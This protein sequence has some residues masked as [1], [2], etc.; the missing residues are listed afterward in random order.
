MRNVSV[1]QCI[2]NALT[3]NNGLILREIMLEAINEELPV[4]L[5]FSGISLFATVCFNASVGFII[6]EYGP[7][8]FDKSII[9]SNLSKGGEEAYQHSYDNAV[10][11][12]RKDTIERSMQDSAIE[13]LLEGNF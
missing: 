7:D 1:N 9:I 5:D 2:D 13:D 6:F 4:N 12:Y 3:E 10:S 11:Y 8:K